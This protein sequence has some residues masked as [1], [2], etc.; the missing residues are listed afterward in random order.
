MKGKKKGFINVGSEMPKKKKKKR[1]RPNER[2]R[3]CRILWHDQ[4]SRHP[5]LP[6]NKQ[7]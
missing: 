6:H 1:N 4:T 2:K 3:S 7:F 5:K